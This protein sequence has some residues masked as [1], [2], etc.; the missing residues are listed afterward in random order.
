MLLDCTLKMSNREGF[1]LCMF[2][3]NKKVNKHLNS[4]E[5]K[6]ISREEYRVCEKALRWQQKQV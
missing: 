6:E 4:F 2:F 3:N 1:M 5:I